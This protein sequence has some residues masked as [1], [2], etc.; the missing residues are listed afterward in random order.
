MTDRTAGTTDPLHPLLAERWSTR[1]FDATAEVDDTTL[2]AL[3]EAAR[4]APSAMNSQPWRFVV[5]RRGTPE[6]AELLDLLAPRNAEWAGRAGALLLVLSQE[7][8]EEGRPQPWA[9]YDTGQAVAQL[10]VQAQAL[11]LAVH[12]MGGFDHAGAVLRLDLPGTLRPVVVLAVGAADPGAELPSPLAARETAPR[13]RRSLE[14]LLL[15][16][17]PAHRTAA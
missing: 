8:D 1:A 6:H 3:L 11:G 2:T 5:G 13:V 7:V 4:W 12:Q 14:Q 10:T 17:L 9:A 15:H 16:P